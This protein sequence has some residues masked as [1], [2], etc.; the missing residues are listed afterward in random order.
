MRFAARC[1]TI[2]AGMGFRYLAALVLFCACGRD[3]ILRDDQKPPSVLTLLTLSLPAG[4]ED[5]MY[6]TTLLADGPDLDAIRW[7]V[8]TSEIP[9]L[10]LRLA[11][12]SAALLAGIP[13]DAGRFAVQI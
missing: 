6:G 2:S 12:G 10:E 11:T 3:Q 5:Q 1:V 7:R 8:V 9:E 4:M 13:P